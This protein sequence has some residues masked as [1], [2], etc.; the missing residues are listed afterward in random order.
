MDAAVTPPTYRERLRLEGGV[1]AALGLA[2]SV[3][4][5]ALA[6]GATDVPASTVGQLLLVALLLAI[7]APRGAHAALASAEALAS[8]VEAGSGE[9]TP[10]WHLP[11]VV[12]VLAAPLLLLGAPDAALRVT[13]GCALVGLAQAVVLAGIVARAERAQGRAYVRRPGSRILRGTKLGWWPAGEP[14]SSG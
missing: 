6:D 3:A 13:G 9:P 11:L 7:F 12:A 4:L 14:A 5:L 8:P 10:L 1:L 2:G